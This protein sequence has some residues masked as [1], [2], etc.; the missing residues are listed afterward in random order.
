VVE[1]DPISMVVVRKFERFRGKKK[2]LDER[3]GGGG[4]S[5]RMINWNVVNREHHMHCIAL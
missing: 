3:Q 5:L 2:E 4:K 1:R